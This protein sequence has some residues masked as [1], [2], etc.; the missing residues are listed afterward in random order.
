[1]LGSTYNF[2]N[3]SCSFFGS[4]SSICGSS[5]GYDSRTLARMARWTLDFTLDLEPGV[6]LVNLVSLST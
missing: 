1:M 6:M 4:I 3:S 2:N 5:K